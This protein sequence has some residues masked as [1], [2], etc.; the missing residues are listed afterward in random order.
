MV[1][2]DGAE[3]QGPG[4]LPR[5][6]H[7][8]VAEVDAVDRGLVHRPHR[9]GVAQPDQVVLDPRRAHHPD[10]RSPPASAAASEKACNKKGHPKQW[11]A[12]KCDTTTT[13]MSSTANPQRRRCGRAV[14]DG[15]TSTVP[16]MTKLFQ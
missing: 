3:A 1:D 16:S 12:W 2:L 15:S 4:L 11:S 13:S 8:D 10:H 14:G 6:V 9:A 5:P 7:L